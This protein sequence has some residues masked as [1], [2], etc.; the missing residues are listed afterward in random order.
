MVKHIRG[1]HRQRYFQTPWNVC[2][3]VT[4]DNSDGNH[5]LHLDKRRRHYFFILLPIFNLS[6][7]RKTASMLGNGRT[8]YLLE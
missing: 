7:C 3:K 8:S 1:S 2:E 5:K 4:D 6:K